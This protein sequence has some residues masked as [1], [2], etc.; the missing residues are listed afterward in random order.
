MVGA[1]RLMTI[2]TMLWGAITIGTAFVKNYEQLIACRVLLGAAEA[3]ESVESL[4]L[5]RY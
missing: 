5:A 2:S 4:A 3:G 1:R